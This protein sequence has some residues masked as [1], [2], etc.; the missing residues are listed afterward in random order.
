MELKIV[1]LKIIGLIQ[2]IIGGSMVFFVFILFYNFL[3]IQS[4]LGIS[5]NEISI[6]LW[7]LAI[8]GLLSTINGLFLLYE[9]Q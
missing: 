7:M 1:I 2:T 6:Y 5:S 8:F 3:N 4:V 9:K